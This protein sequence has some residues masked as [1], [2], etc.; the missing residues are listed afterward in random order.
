MPVLDFMAIHP[1]VVKQC[2][3]SASVMGGDRLRVLVDSGG[4]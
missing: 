3:S 2:V 4:R 1:A